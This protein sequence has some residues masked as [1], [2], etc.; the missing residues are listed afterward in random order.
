MTLQTHPDYYVRWR[1]E[2]LAPKGETAAF[3]KL[4]LIPRFNDWASWILEIRAEHLNATFLDWKNSLEV[5]RKSESFVAGPITTIDHLNYKKDRYKISGVGHMVHLDDRLATPEPAG[6]PYTTDA[7][8]IQ[9]STDAETQL[10]YYVDAHC[11]PGAKV[12]RQ[13]LTIATNQNRGSSLPGRARFYNLLAMCQSMALQGGDLGFKVTLEGTELEFEVYEPTDLTGDVKLSRE[14]GTLVGYRVIS[15]A[16]TTN[17]V[18]GA[19]GGQ[20]ITRIFREGEDTASQTKYDRRIESFRDRRDTTDTDEID[21]SIQEELDK[22]ADRV[23]VELYPTETEQARP[24]DDYYVGDKITATVDGVTYTTPVREMNIV[25][26]ANMET[27]V[28]VVGSPG[29]ADSNALSDL[30]SKLQNVQSQ[31]ALIQKE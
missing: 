8:D 2:N 1:D 12:A 5:F 20:G 7:Y 23:S 3:E 17:H 25:V 19:G 13:K 16:P 11:G 10:K 6:P 9:A 22:G 24:I 26:E 28:P 18:T 27:V 30:Y 31:L 4:T 14:L 15:N 29:R 21:K